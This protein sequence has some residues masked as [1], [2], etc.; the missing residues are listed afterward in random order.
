MVVVF[1]IANCDT[2]K[3]ARTW[4]SAHTIAY[5]FHD[6][7]KSG[8]DPARVRRWCDQLG[9]EVVLNRSGTT[10]KKLDTALTK[11]MTKETAILLMCEYPS[12]IKRPI[13]D[14]KNAVHAGFLPEKYE[15]IFSD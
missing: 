5:D 10:F 9:W 14:A 7:K 15:R 8:I 11:N 12:M 13:L 1:G 4:L 3:K 6:Y 2:M